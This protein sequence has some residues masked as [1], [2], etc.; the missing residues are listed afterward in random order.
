MNGITS[1]LLS[2]ASKLERYNTMSNIL[3]YPQ[4]RLPSSST[5]N[6]RPCLLNA[7]TRGSLPSDSLKADITARVVA[8]L[9]WHKSI[10]TATPGGGP[11]VAAGPR[12]SPLV[13]LARPS[14]PA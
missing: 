10:A 7:F 11:T 2:N 6:P 14:R 5:L 3:T 12:G 1:D 9:R 13:W 4:R 8:S